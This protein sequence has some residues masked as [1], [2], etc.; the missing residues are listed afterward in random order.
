VPAA[1]RER[2]HHGNRDREAEASQPVRD[3]AGKIV[4]RPDGR[5]RRADHDVMLGL[6]ERDVDEHDALERVDAA[7]PCPAELAGH[8]PFP[9]AHDD[10]RLG[11]ACEP[12]HHV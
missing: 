10:V 11:G 4:W 9:E 6:L 12:L 5:E 2:G 3:D 1:P 8:A 7:E